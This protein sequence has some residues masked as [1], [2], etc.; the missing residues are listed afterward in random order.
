MSSLKAVFLF[1]LLGGSVISLVIFIRLLQKKI[2]LKRAILFM[3]IFGSFSLIVFYPYR[4][5]I[6]G[7]YRRIQHKIELPKDAALTCNCE[8]LEVTKDSY[9]NQH[10]PL[11]IRF[12]KNGFI[13]DEATLT[14][15]LRRK[16]LVLVDEADGYYIQNLTSSSKH[17]TP[18]AKKRLEE[19]ALLFRSFLK[20]SKNE[21]DYFVI[22]SMTRT[23]TQQD[24]IRR[25]YPNSATPGKST[26]SFGVSFDISRVKSIGSCDV[27][28]RALIKALNQMRDEKK[29]LLCPEFKCIHIT[30]IN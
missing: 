24:E 18:I 23:E 28:Q 20:D 10:R 25:K 2:T 19:L 15:F 29:I 6:R 9:P 13:K 1:F 30:V 5:R 26:H 16:R 14:N 12:T 4:S 21:K 8:S 11:A 3:F 7:Y 17:L 22:S 27:S